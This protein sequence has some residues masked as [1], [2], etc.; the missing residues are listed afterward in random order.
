MGRR[1]EDRPSATACLIAACVAFQSRDE[2]AVA[3]SETFVRA[4]SLSGRWLIQVIRRPWFRRLART[5]E[6]LTLPGFMQ[7]VVLR[8]RYIEQVAR[9]SVAQGTSQVLVL[10]GGYDTLAL[11]L[12][13]DAR[14]FEIDRP[15]TQRVKTGALGEHSVTFLPM[16]LATESLQKGLEEAEEYDSRART[17]FVAEGLLMYL[18]QG[19]VTRLFRSFRELGGDGSRV[20]FSFMATE[21]DGK[22]RF[23]NCRRWVDTW[24]NLRGEPFQWGIPRTELPRFLEQQGLRLVELVDAETFRERYE[25]VGALAEGE[26]LAVAEFP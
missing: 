7:H 17:L 25:A 22:V 21:G 2:R 5:F 4:H 1:K 3:L 18:E 23:R 26:R 11:R 15:A 16:D 12:D 20:V 8:K 9:S 14:C 24:L 10:G 6:R 13:S 19:D